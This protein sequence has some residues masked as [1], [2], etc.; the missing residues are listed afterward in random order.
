M[1][2]AIGQVSNRDEARL[3]RAIGLSYSSECK[4]RHGALIYKSNRLISSGVNSSRVHNK[5]LKNY[6]EK[7]A[8][9]HAEER[10]IRNAQALVGED[11]SGM[12][13]YVARSYKNG[14]PAMSAPCKNCQKLIKKSGL[15]KVIYTIGEP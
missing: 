7:P 14:K 12:V 6:T 13:L 2:A 4:Q 11:L 10:A 5:Y 3:N 9:F 1:S 15:K 8:T